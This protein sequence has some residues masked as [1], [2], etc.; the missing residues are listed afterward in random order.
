MQKGWKT[1]LTIYLS[2]WL[3]VD[4]IKIHWQPKFTHVIQEKHMNI[5]YKNE[6]YNVLKSFFNRS[7]CCTW[8]EPMPQQ[9]NSMIMSNNLQITC[10]HMEKLRREGESTGWDWIGVRRWIWLDPWK[11]CAVQPWDW[12]WDGSM[13]NNNLASRW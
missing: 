1:T 10:K 13:P 6:K 2:L 12:D 5:R 7:S 8:T 9:T 11:K 4:L 3:F